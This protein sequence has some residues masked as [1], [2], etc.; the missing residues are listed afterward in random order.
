MSDD[1]AVVVVEDEEEARTFLVQILQYEG[2]NAIGFANGLEALEYLQKAEPPC[3][4]VLD[5]RMPMM[6]GPEFRAAQLSD[7]GAFGGVRSLAIAGFPEACRRGRLDQSCSGKLLA[8]CEIF[9]PSILGFAS[10]VEPDLV[11]GVR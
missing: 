8:S 4:I 3:L 9:D 10:S 6:D 7:P 2:F 1:D 11:C 5:L